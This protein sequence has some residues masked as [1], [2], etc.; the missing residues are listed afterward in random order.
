MEEIFELNPRYATVE[1]KNVDIKQINILRRKKVDIL[2][3]GVV[4]ESAVVEHFMPNI[5]HTKMY[6]TGD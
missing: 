1:L 4:M 6:F 5:N 3:K 2:L